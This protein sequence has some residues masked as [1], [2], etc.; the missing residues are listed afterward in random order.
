MFLMFRAN[1][2]N[3]R[4]NHRDAAAG[5]SHTACL[6]KAALRDPLEGFRSAASEF[7]STSSVH[8][9]PVALAGNAPG[10]AHEWRIVIQVM[11]CKPPNDKRIYSATVHVKSGSSSCLPPLKDGS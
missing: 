11:T 3:G 8:E 9:V 5:V 10:R 2:T 7:A 1:E 4:E 6:G